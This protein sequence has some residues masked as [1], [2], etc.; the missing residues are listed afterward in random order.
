M[1]EQASTPS[2]F[3]PADWKVCLPVA[4]GVD[5]QADIPSARAD[6][7]SLAYAKAIAIAYAEAT[8]YAVASAT[9]KEAA[10]G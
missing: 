5:L 7:C 1:F 2:D 10:A 3:R 9:S 4:A 6:Y 8:A